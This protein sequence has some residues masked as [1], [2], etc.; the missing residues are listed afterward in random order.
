LDHKWG[1]N[2]SAYG[3]G[4]TGATLAARILTLATA[5]AI[6]NV[7]SPGGTVMSWQ[8]LGN[9]QGYMPGGFLT[10]PDPSENFPYGFIVEADGPV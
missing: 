8:Y 3:L 7:R 6:I 10:M 2:V 5:T 9:I 1:R 4:D